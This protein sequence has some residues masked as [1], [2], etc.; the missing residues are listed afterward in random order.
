VRSPTVNSFV[1][2]VGG[3]GQAPQAA[4][5]TAAAS[6]VPSDQMGKLGSYSMPKIGLE[7]W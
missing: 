3:C 7:A 4:V 2:A 1:V 6:V 5:K